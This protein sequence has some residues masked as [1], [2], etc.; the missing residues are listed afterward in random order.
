MRYKA[1]KAV[2]L[3]VCGVFIVLAIVWAAIR[4]LGAGLVLLGL[5]AILSY[6]YADYCDFARFRAAMKAREVQPC[7]RCRTA[8]RIGKRRCPECKGRGWVVAPPD[9][10]RPPIT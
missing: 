2:A 10:G 8:G 6:E 9:Y 5:L 7:L 4:G 1:L 3:V